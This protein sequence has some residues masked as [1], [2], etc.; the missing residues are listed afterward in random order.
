MGQGSRDSGALHWIIVLLVFSITGSLALVVAR[1][2]LQDLL[3]L[4]G[5][6]WAGPWSYRIAYLLVVPPCY[7]M[8]LV[9]IGGI[10]GKY[11]YFRVRALKTWSRL[12]PGPLG[13]K[14]AARA[15]R[16]S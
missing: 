6:F 4:Q 13:R 2:L 16:G 12:L 3:G 9:L 10:F 5:G 1:L 14:L 11:E 15:G 8:M 7:S